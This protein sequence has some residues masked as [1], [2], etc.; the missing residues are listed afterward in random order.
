MLIPVVV[1]VIVAAVFVIIIVILISIGCCCYWKRLLRVKYEV[2]NVARVEENK[3]EAVVN[4][5][6]ILSEVRNTVT[7][8][9]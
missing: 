5:S 7:A 9:A 8:C 1:S 6:N 3:L 4:A 2:K